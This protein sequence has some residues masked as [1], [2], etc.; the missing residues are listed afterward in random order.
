MV[1]G[2]VS[3]LGPTIQ[4][5]PALSPLFG[6]GDFGT[7]LLLEECNQVGYVLIV[8]IKLHWSDGYVNALYL[9]DVSDVPHV[10]GVVVIDN[11]D[12]PV[13]LVVRDGGGVGIARVRRVRC[14]VR[15]RKALGHIYPG[16]G[17]SVISS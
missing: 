7:V 17:G 2:L 16:R 3:N 12:L 15:D 10:D 9:F 6:T 1:S 13:G 8:A 14:H 4:F 11:C 5:C